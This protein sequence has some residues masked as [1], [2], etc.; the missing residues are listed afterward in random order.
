MYLRI[1]LGTDGSPDSR[2]ATGVAA[3]MTK[4]FE[5]ELTVAA[6][7]IEHGS[8]TVPW[9]SETDDHPIPDEVAEKWARSEQAWLS[10]QGIEAA[11]KV[12]HG[13]AAEALAKE[14]SQ[15]GYDLMIVGHRGRSAGGAAVR[16]TGSVA[17]DLVDLAECP[18]LI[19]P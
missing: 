13:R 1:L 14:A 18:L 5:T 8:P 17:A 11:V 16:R 4:A 7:A 10:E 12:L 3:A 2:R 19:V 6:V 15:G 9:S